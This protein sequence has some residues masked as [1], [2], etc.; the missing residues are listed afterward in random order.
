MGLTDH[1]DTVRALART[2][3]LSPVR[4]DVAVRMAREAGKWGQTAAAAVALSAHRH[5]DRLAIID[6]AGQLTWADLERRTN[7]LAAGL[8]ARGL[9]AEGS[10]VGILCRNH[11]GFVEAL[12]ATA[13]LG[14]DAVLLNTGFAGP[15][16][17]EVS[18]REGVHLLLHDPSFAGVV[19]DSGLGGEDGVSVLA[20]WPDELLE[21]EAEAAT[22]PAAGREGHVVI[23]SSGTTGTPKGAKRDLSGGGGR[24]RLSSLASSL[25]ML[26]RL[27]LKGGETT[28]IAAPL[29]HTWGLSHALLCAAFG[30][31]MVLRERFD[32]EDALAAVARELAGALVAVPAML[33]R[34]LALPDDVRRRHDTSSL[35]LVALSGSALPGGLATRWMDAF[36]DNLYSLYGSTE[37]AAVALAQP[38]DLR[39]APDTA[40]PIVPG[41][42][43]RLLDAEGRAVEA[44]QTGR[45]FVRSGL[46]FEGYTGGGNKEVIDGYMSTGD[47]GHFDGAGRLYVDG[48]EDDM[49]VSG[50][51]NVFPQEVEEVILTL[52]SVAD[53]AVVGVPDDEF[54]QRLRAVVVAAQ[55]A[56][57]TADEV[58]DH[59]R[60]NLARYKVPRDVVVRDELP[61]NT[62][63]KVLRRVLAGDAET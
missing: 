46:L 41:V 21:G 59:V 48:R 19:A 2:G 38:A 52:P 36:G 16:L 29:F 54:G 43:V 58:R 56:T 23:L 15:Q 51:E 5:P 32:P 3:I 57:P 44:G 30:S 4:P 9:A 39:A 31:P 55:G 28:L 17:A 13:K 20:V 40:G 8:R 22:L 33:Q 35:R 60:R 14:A 49:I 37:V 18:R 24:S 61:R 42:D 62:T 53:C 10:V 63:G 25:G 7:A 27:P 50:G 26:R 11:R 6:E 12:V 1:L 47:V 34:V 45:I